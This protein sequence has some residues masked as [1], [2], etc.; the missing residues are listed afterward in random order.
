[1]LAAFARHRAHP[2]RTG[3]LAQR[4]GPDQPLGRLGC[5]ATAPDLEEKLR[6]PLVEACQ[7]FIEPGDL[8]RERGV[9]AKLL[10]GLAAAQAQRFV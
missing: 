9:I 4:V 3:T 5:L 1:M 7:L 6:P 10:Q 8:A 2:G